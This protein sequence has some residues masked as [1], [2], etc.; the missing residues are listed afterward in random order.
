MSPIE[1]SRLQQSPESW[2]C[3]SCYKEAFLYHN[4]SG[5]SIFEVSC[6]SSTSL[7]NNSIIP[8][9]SPSVNNYS[10]DSISVLYSN[11]R[12]LLPKIDKLRLQASAT[13]ADIVC[14]VETWLDATI[15]NA[16]IYI[17]GYQIG[18]KDRNRHGGD[19]LLYVKTSIPVFSHFLHPKLELLT[20]ET[21]VQN[22]CLTTCLFYRPPN[23][24]PHCLQELEGTLDHLSPSKLKTLMLVGDFNIN[25]H[26]PSQLQHQL[27]CITSKYGL[28]QMVQ[29]PTRITEHNSS[30]IDHLY[31]SDSSLITSCHT[32]SP[33][34]SSDHLSILAHLSLHTPHHRPK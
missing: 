21:R 27:E 16:E 7:H 25:L 30:L 29:D 12:S 10:N 32:H 6:N 4:Y 9:P 20:V 24:N 28:T 31:V 23:A 26:Q 3:G 8:P 19:I 11:C 5:T 34:G 22:K 14:I 17:P 18:R 13:N 2:S 33:I 1:Y 15:L